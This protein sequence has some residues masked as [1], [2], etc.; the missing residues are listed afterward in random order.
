MSSTDVRETE[1]R[2]DRGSRQDDI[3]Q[4]V[5]SENDPGYHWTSFVIIAYDIGCIFNH[6][7][8]AFDYDYGGLSNKESRLLK[9]YS[10]LLCVLLNSLHTSN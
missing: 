8:A 5:V 7:T 9:A 2:V 3:H 10:N 4:Q 6:H 1:A